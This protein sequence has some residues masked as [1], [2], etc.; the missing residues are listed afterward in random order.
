MIRIEHLK[1]NYGKVCAVNDI[2]FTIEKGEIVGFLGPNGAGKSTTM[3][4]LCGYLSCNQGKAKIC[5][6]DILEN[7]IEAK[8][9]IGYLPELPP[10]YPD[11][12]VDEYLSFIYELKGSTLKKKEHLD[13]ICQVT[14]IEDVR[15]RLIKHLSKG[16]KQRVGIAQ[17]LVGNPEVLIFDEPTVG[18]DP[19][20]IVEVRSLIKSLA[21]KHTVILSTHILSE[22]QAVCDRIIIISNGKIVANEKTE[23]ISKAVTNVS[24]LTIKIC[25]PEKEVTNAISSLTGISYVESLGRQD[26]DSITF[27]VSCQAGLDMRKPLFNLMAANHWP[28]IGLEAQGLDLEDVFLTAVDEKPAASAKKGRKRG[29]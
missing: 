17:A 25:G 2:S 15:G 22:V 19:K 26:M 6:I 12:T 18:L 9:K 27:A 4:I 29:K 23:E 5:G 1:K 14:S 7:P 13:E 11:M 20:Q 3:N 28:I 24:K 10:L 21:H 16:Y 8:K